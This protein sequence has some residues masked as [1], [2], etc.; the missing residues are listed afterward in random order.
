MTSVNPHFTF[1]YDQPSEYHF[2]HD[3]VFLARRVFEL[4]QSQDLS[5][6]RVLDL[7]A[8]CGIIGLD[9]LFHVF[10]NNKSLPVEVDF[11]EVQDIYHSYFATN[12][13]AF[14]QNISGSKNQID[15]QFMNLNYQQMLDIS[16]FKDRYDLIISNP[17]Y[18]RQE[19]GVLSRSDFKNRCRFFIDSDFQTLLLAIQFSLAPCGEA[20]VLLKSL[21]DHGI[22][23]PK[24]ISNFKLDMELS[25]IG[26]IRDTDLYHI[27]K[28]VKF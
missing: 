16:Q 13:Q 23:I 10:K 4:T 26:V 2:S 8:G 25:K 6:K 14:R 24:E 22:S 28:K 7:C 21:D 5:Q 9:F 19:Q 11:L 1:Q 18:F 15:L 27:S 12:V 17:P 3:S 20:Y